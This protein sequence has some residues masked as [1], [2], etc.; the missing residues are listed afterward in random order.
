MTE[1]GWGWAS[2]REMEIELPSLG[3]NR[4]FGPTLKSGDLILCPFGHLR[5]QGGRLGP[6]D[7]KV[8]A[9]DDLASEGV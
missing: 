8:V 4:S 5:P 6:E 7:L 9:D 2:F 1:R 3:G